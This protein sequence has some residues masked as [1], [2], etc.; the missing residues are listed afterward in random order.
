MGKCG[1]EKNKLPAQFIAAFLTSTF[2][3]H[4]D[5]IIVKSGNQFRN[6]PRRN[7]KEILKHLEERAGK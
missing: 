4:S 7:V 5:F 1:P 3:C 6:N 2:K